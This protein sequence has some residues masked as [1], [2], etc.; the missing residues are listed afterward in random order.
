MSRLPDNA[1]LTDVNRISCTVHALLPSSGKYGQMNWSTSQ[2][3]SQY[4]PLSMAF[5]VAE[6]P[7]VSLAYVRAS[8]VVI[9][10]RTTVLLEASHFGSDAGSNM[11][12]VSIA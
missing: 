4:L 12:A 5:A 3:S 8:S 2:V 1:V 9:A 6:G 10:A 11:S 7:F